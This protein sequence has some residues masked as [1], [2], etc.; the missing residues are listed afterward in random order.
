MILVPFS[1]SAV[2]PGPFQPISCWPWSPPAYQL[3]TLVPSS[4]WA[5]DPG[6]LQPIS[7]WRWFLQPISRWRWA[8]QLLTL[9]A[10]ANQL[11]TTDSHLHPF[12]S[13]SFSESNTSPCGCDTLMCLFTLPTPSSPSQ[14]DNVPQTRTRYMHNNDL[15][16]PGYP[17]PLYL[18]ALEC[19]PDIIL[20][21][22]CKSSESSGN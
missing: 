16:E 21:R 9:V 22:Y 11:W 19:V 12:S 8:N 18:F 7:F 3:L 4:Q 17:R 14:G 5:I 13:A 2:E 6:P 15:C 1:Q 20:Y 10:S